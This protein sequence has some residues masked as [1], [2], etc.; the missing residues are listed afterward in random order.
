MLMLATSLDIE[1]IDERIRLSWAFKVSI[2]TSPIAAVD[3]TSKAELK[4]LY[5]KLQRL[6]TMTMP[7]YGNGKKGFEGILLDFTLGKLWEKQLSL[8]DSLSYSF[9]DETPWDIDAGAS[10]GIDVSIGLKLL[11]NV[12]P[13]YNSKVYDLGGI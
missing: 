11:G 2:K 5:S 4:P 3:I 6:S 10:M 7:N 13:T 9:S 1:S 12:V 8:I